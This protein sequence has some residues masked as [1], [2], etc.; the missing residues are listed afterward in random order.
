MLKRWYLVLVV[1]MF[2]LALPGP[3]LAQG[4]DEGVHFGKYELDEGDFDYGDQVVF[5]SA[6][7]EEGS[8]LEGDLLVFGDAE[9]AGEVDGDVFCAGAVQ[10]RDSAYVSGD[11]SATGSVVVD[12]EA[13]IEGEVTNIADVSEMHWRVPGGGP[14]EIDPVVRSVNSPWLRTLS[15]MLRGIA[16]LV[17]MGVLAIVVVSIWPHQTERV[18]RAIIEAPVTAFGMGILT[19]LVSSIV[20]VILAVL[21]CT[22]PFAMIGAVVL[23]VG[24]ALGW[25][26]LG[27]MLGDRV[28]EGLFNRSQTKIMSAL[29][30]TLLLT[31]VAAM[32]NVIW[33]F[34]YVVLMMLLTSPAIG[35]VILTR[36]GSVPYATRGSV[37]G[38]PSAV[39]TSPP[40]PSVSPAAPVGESEEVTGEEV[41]TSEAS[42]DVIELR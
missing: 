27:L 11:V 29:V 13:W 1:A 28:M 38:M 34:L 10:L 33:G 5:G 15:R 40:T 42:D 35:A 26:A 7:L 2:V 12:E 17:V 37:T 32:A 3:V 25:I 19:F 20:L 4:G 16:S 14:I 39:S 36:F 30:G 21:I 18:G 9:I 6:D 23:G 8:R 22:I 41:A 24:V 31:G